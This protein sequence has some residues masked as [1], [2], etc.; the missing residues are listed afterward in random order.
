MLR[1]RAAVTDVVASS[2][3]RNRTLMGSGARCTAAAAVAEART[4]CSRSGVSAAG[5]RPRRCS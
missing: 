1:I 3:I 2:E 4:P 5:K